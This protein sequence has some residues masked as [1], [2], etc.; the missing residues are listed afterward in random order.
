MMT[1]QAIH[2]YWAKN[3]KSEKIVPEIDLMGKKLPVFRCSKEK[4]ME[5]GFMGIEKF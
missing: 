5:S 4:D 1:Y 2:Y 3:Q